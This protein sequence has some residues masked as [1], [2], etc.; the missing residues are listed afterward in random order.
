M[1]KAQEHPLVIAARHLADE[2]ERFEVLSAELARMP[3]NS[4]KS[5]Q[6]A[7]QGLE[8]CAEHEAKLAET[9]RGFA[10]AMQQTQAAQ[11]RCIELGSAA[12]GRIQERQAQRA[13]LQ[14]RLARLGQ[15]A[16]EV[17]APVASLP[18]GSAGMSSHMLGPLQEVERRLD[19]VIAE[20]GE[21]S[22]VAQRDDWTDLQRDTQ[23]LQQQLQALRNKILLLR[24]KLAET[25]A[26]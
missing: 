15:N 7:R 25:A 16:R 14:Q 19:A 21:V 9:L 17:S 26:S 20:A 13:E 10:Q 11:A 1:S 2:L 3:I 5:L 6:R 23:A 12:A 4:E 22:A 24:R 8:A 18:E